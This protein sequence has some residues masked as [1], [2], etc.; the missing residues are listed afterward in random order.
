MPEFSSHNTTVS[1]RSG[2]LSPHHS[3]F[4]GFFV[5]FGHS[6]SFGTVNKCNTFAKVEVC[7]LLFIDTFNP[8]KGGVGLLIAKTS[9]VAKDNAFGI[10][11]RRLLRHFNLLV[12]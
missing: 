1:M 12:T 8:D 10:Q 2:N 9:F 4:A 6:L 5:S 3:D 7:F 11:A